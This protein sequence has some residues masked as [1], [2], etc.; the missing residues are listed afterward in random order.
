MKLLTYNLFFCI[1][2][3]TTYYVGAVEGTLTK[4]SITVSLINLL[5][6]LLYNVK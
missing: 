6:T 1:V 2:A 4:L 5:L 3:A